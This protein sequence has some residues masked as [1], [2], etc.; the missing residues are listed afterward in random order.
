MPPSLLLAG[1]NRAFACWLSYYFPFPAPLHTAAAVTRPKCRTRCRGH[2]GPAAALACLPPPRLIPACCTNARAPL[3]RTCTTARVPGWP[4]PPPPGTPPGRPPGASAEGTGVG[5][6]KAGTGEGG[7]VAGR[8]MLTPTPST[9]SSWPAA[10]SPQ[11]CPRG[12]PGWP[13]AARRRHLTRTTGLAIIVKGGVASPRP[14]QAN[15]K[16]ASFVAF[17]LVSLAALEW[18]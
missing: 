9:R 6:S 18:K 8:A 5:R 11:W 7:R 10:A 12:R 2:H 13:G 16:E 15:A 14:G 1:G 3:R 17:S 4:S